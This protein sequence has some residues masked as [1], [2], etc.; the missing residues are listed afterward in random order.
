MKT[1]TYRPSTLDD[2]PSI[3]NIL[4]SVGGDS[5]DIE[6]SPFILACEDEEIVGCVRLKKLAADSFELASLAV[7][8]EH[9]G[10]NIGSQ[11][12][13]RIVKTQS[14]KIYLL[15]FKDRQP[16]Y[17]QNGFGEIDKNHLPDVLL[18]EYLRV[19]NIFK[20][21]SKILCMEFIQ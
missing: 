12:V 13:Q 16:F 17:D 7:I 20:D 18:A 14:G 9:R 5:S 10:Q 11:L 1:L 19:K 8:P 3:K 21:E 15:C 6:T 2:L 4:L